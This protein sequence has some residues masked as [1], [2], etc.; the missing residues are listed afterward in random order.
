MALRN[1]LHVKFHNF[2]WK[3]IFPQDETHEK[4]HRY[5]RTYVVQLSRLYNVGVTVRDMDEIKQPMAN[6]MH[7]VSRFGLLF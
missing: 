2:P 1:I 6:Y 5:V 3:I 7:A 4:S